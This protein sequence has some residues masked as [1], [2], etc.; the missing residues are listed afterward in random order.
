MQKFVIG[1]DVGGTNVK[2]GLVSL[3]GGIVDRTILNTKTYIRDKKVLTAAI[4][5]GVRELLKNNHVPKQKLLG[6]GIGLPGLIDPIKGIV[7]FLPNI[8]R[9]RDVPLK[10]IM[11]KELNVPTFL[12]NDVNL[13][14]LGEWKFGAGRGNRDLV[15]VTLGTG[16]GGGLIL[17]NQ[18]YRGPGFCSGEIGHIPLNESGPKCNCGGRACLERYVGNRYLLE[19]IKKIFKKELSLE[20]VHV[21]AIQ[22]NPKALRF[23]QETAVQIGNGLV[24]LVNLLNPTRII[25]GG[26]IANCHQFLFPTIQQTIKKRAMRVQG[27][28]AK[29][30]KAQLGNDGGLFGATVLVQQTMNKEL[31]IA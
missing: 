8:P 30:V 7:N 26:G 16:V 18:L 15:C 29:I 11:E 19:R 12:E 31:S 22:G 25:I 27:A 9:W 5:E 21:L 14:A 2:L 17:N 20:E 28:M 4:C 1:I 24:G 23:W 13:I 3:S 10:K 6:I